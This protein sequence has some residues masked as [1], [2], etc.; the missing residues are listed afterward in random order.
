MHSCS[1]FCRA[2]NRAVELVLQDA[3]PRAIV[4]GLM[5][6][7]AAVGAV[8]SPRGRGLAHVA[9]GAAVGA[10][11]GFFMKAITPAVQ[12][13]VCGSCGCDGVVA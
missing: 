5:S 11:V 8:Q 7:G 13:R 1:G 12:R 10:G 2:C 4:P 3:A 9:L 6:L